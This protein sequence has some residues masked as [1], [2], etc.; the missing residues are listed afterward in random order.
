MN[1][2]IN[3][4]YNEATNNGTPINYQI[5]KFIYAE[6]SFPMKNRIFVAI[7][8]IALCVTIFAGCASADVQEQPAAPAE[9]KVV[10]IFDEAYMLQ[11]TTSL[12]DVE[13]GYA[14]GASSEGATFHG[15]QDGSTIIQ[16]APVPLAPAPEAKQLTKEEA[17]AIA[18]KYAN[19]SASEVTDLRVELDE[20][21]YD[22]EFRHGGYEYDFEI[23]AESGKIL[24][25]EKEAIG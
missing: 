10:A 16:D 21:E 15:V 14:E 22:V 11:N 25:G 18:L 19:L 6:R 3:A 7:M 1:S 8:L 9:E 23:H 4:Q 17:Q 12:V 2:E 13:A 5:S 20:N 24:S